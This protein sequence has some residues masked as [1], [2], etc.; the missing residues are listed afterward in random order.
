MFHPV[1]ILKSVGLGA[2]I[3]YLLD[4]ASGNRRRALIRDQLVRVCNV[5]NQTAETVYRDASNRMQG[6]KAEIGSLMEPSEQGI[7]ERVQ[8][9]AIN[10]GRTLGMQGRT[11]S[12]TGKATIALVGATCVAALLNKRDLGALLLGGLGLSYIANELSCSHTARSTASA[13]QQPKKNSAA[14]DD[15]QAAPA[16]SKHAVTQNS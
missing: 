9:T 6:V 16:Q 5:T 11:M 2:G 3:M 14:G 8:E 4:P 13:P 10:V 7:G 1:T 15:Q 12:P